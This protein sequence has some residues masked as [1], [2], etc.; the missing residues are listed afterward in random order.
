MPGKE[1]FKIYIAAYL[2]L[3]KDGHVLLL[4]RANT[5][6]QDGNYGL[7]A[8]HLDGGETAKQCIIRE[9][10]EEAGIKLKPADLEVVHVMHRYRSEREYI[11][12]YL[13]SHVWGG[14]ITNMEPDKC[15]ELKWF[16]LDNLP[17]NLIPELK[18]ALENTKKNV[19]YGEIGW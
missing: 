4:R 18:L 3:A 12:I 15:H 1:R 8:G 7:V 16:P 9:A 5:G 14:D 6:Y 11:D 10:L 13:K 17:E 19:F 2:I